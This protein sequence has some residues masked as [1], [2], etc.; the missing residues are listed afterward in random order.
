MGNY[1]SNYFFNISGYLS[2]IVILIIGFIFLKEGLEN[3][4]G[5]VYYK[6]TFW[7]L[8]FL[9]ISVSIDA[10]R[11]GFSVLNQY[12]IT[13]IVN[14][15]LLIGLVASIF[16]LIAVVIVKYIYNLIL[17]EKYAEYFVGIILILFGIKM[18]FS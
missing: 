1:I 10:L 13:V 12:S 16:T 11:I 8:V 7:K 6:L 2:G 9:G 3:Q 18:F 15:S 5:C 4:E 17:V 14:N